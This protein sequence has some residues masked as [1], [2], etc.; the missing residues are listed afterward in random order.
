M[1]KPNLER[2]QRVARRRATRA[3]AKQARAKRRRKATEQQERWRDGGAFRS[4]GA[5]SAGVT[6]YAKPAY[7]PEVTVARRAA[8]HGAARGG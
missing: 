1:K 6:R 5:G 3:A 4:R 2:E 7:T 8:G